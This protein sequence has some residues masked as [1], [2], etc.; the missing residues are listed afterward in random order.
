[1]ADSVG[2]FVAAAHCYIPIHSH[3]NFDKQVEATL[4]GVALLDSHHT[5]NGSRKF[6]DF[7]LK[8]VGLGRIHDFTQGRAKYA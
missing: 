3:M 5:G 2:D 6:A 1:M 7:P 4:A 8:T